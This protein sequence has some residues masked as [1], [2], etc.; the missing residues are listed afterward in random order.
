MKVD[1][2]TDGVKPA[3][4]EY[5]ANHLTVY[6]S[7]TGEPIAYYLRVRKLRPLN[8]FHSRIYIDIFINN[9]EEISDETEWSDMYDLSRKP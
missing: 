4:Y 5:L 6:D 7:P 2:K 3:F 8:S 9:S 1:I